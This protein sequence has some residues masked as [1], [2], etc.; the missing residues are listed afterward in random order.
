VFNDVEVLW[1][2]LN[3]SGDRTLRNRSLRTGASTIDLLLQLPPILTNTYSL[4]QIYKFPS[5]STKEIRSHLRKHSKVFA[6]SLLS[7]DATS[8]A[9]GATLLANT[10][11]IQRYL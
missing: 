11:L 10:L 2:L 3:S 9:Y 7:L 4:F 5:D 6:L 8:S 1:W